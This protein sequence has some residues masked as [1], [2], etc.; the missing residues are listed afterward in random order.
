VQKIVLNRVDLEKAFHFNN[1][2]IAQNISEL[3]AI[4][5][6]LNS[7]EIKNY[8]NSE[9]N[10]FAN[11]I[12]FVFEEKELAN[13]LK[14]CQTKSEL[15]TTL[16]DFI[17]KTIKKTQDNK[18]KHNKEHHKN[19]K[20]EQTELK[21]NLKQLQKELEQKLKEKNKNTDESILKK[22]IIVWLILAFILGIIIGIILTRF[23]F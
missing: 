11:W 21:K 23:L 14:K 8:V 4:I 13:N 19:Q 2:K 5:E 7:E 22:Y 6:D 1:E 9:K 15:L 3:S 20:K 18:E 12:E 10:D 17:H 16:D